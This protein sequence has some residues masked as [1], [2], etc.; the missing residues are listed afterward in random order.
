MRTSCAAIRGQARA[1]EPR[2]LEMNLSSAE[3]QPVERFENNAGGLVQEPA[4]G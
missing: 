4:R 2:Y 3:R 1:G